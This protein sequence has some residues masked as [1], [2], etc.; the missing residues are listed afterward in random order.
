VRVRFDDGTVCKAR[1]LGEES[2]A[3]GPH[4]AGLTVR[5]AMKLEDPR[6]SLPGVASVRLPGRSS[7][8]RRRRP[9]GEVDLIIAKSKHGLTG[10]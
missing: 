7:F 10:G 3:P 6:A 9:T 2:T 4:H 8:F 1:I 5:L